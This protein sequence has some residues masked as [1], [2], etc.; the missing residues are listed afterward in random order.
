MSPP[1]LETFLRRSTQRAHDPSMLESHAELALDTQHPFFFD[2]P[3][4]HLPGLLL[5]TAMTQ[6]A[7][8]CASHSEAL[9]RQ[10]LYNAALSAR[11]TKWCLFEPEVHLHARGRDA[12]PALFD[13]VARQD[14]APRCEAQVRLEAIPAALAPLVAPRSVEPCD[15]RL[16][17]KHSRAN[18]MIG[19]PV[20]SANRLRAQVLAPPASH[21]LAGPDAQA[22]GTVYLLEAFM[23]TQR[24][25]NKSAE[26][27]GGPRLRD[28]LI[29]VSIAL[30]R[31]IA[32]TEPV[33]V[34]RA[35]N[36]VPAGRG[37]RRHEGD[38]RVGDETVGQCAIVTLGAA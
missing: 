34:D 22:M 24:W 33:D 19:T 13:V 31:P 6:L 25:L 20:L 9:G 12:L 30:H 37:L 11:F 14:G 1:E 3:L 38:L 16:V 36:A 15:Q 10:A 2:H 27:A 23:Q 8:H 32:R 17:N 28:T 21:A 7:W 5:I 29:E 18:V 35:Q 26:A 4:D